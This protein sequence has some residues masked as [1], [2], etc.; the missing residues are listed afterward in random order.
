MTFG[1]NL[2][3]PG[4]SDNSIPQKEYYPQK[5]WMWCDLL[6]GYMWFGIYQLK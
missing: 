2:D 5:L 4:H 3:F 1:E 6:Y